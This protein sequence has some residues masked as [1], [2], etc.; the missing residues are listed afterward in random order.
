MK[1]RKELNNKGFSLVE[2]LIA[3]VILG[4]VV[5]PLLHTFVTAANTTARSRQLGDATLLG[6]N[7]AEVVEATPLNMLLEDPDPSKYFDGA[8]SK[9]FYS[10]DAATGAYTPLAAGTTPT[11]PYYL[12]VQ[13]V[14]SGSSTFNVMISLD[15]TVY[16]SDDPNV[17]G[18]ND[19]EITDYSNMDGV[20]AQSRDVD[21]P[22]RLAWAD[23]KSQADALHPAGGWDQASAEPVRTMTLDITENAGKIYADLYLDYTY[24]YRYNV[25]NEETGAVE[26]FTDSLSAATITYDLMSQGYSPATNGGR[27]PNLY[28]M[29]YPL[30]E[31]DSVTNDIICIENNIAQP[32]KIFLVKERD[33]ILSGEPQYHA[34]VE[35]YVPSGTPSSNYAVI[36]SNIAE[37]LSNSLNTTPLV[38][39]NYRIYRGNYFSVTGHFGGEHGDL[40]SRSARSRLFETT[41]EVFAASDSTFSDPIHTF[42]STK[43]Q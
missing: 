26:T 41:V 13:G 11:E 33:T 6:E 38:G 37:D 27:L 29:Y 31:S 19:L 17:K 40:V 14:R 10:R 7:V 20:Y 2:L 18:I 35:Q 30:Y 28:V 34:T 21:D 9:Q 42:R 15:P 8:A 25:V 43:L 23:F 4:I 5:A 22:D 3:T 12:G 24:T 32:I 36:Y 1:M 39:V 16:R